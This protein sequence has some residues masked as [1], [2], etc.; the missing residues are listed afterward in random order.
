M[1]EWIELMNWCK[2]NGLNPTNIK[3]VLTSW[4]LANETGEEPFAENTGKKKKK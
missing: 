2:E 1:G 4:M 3:A